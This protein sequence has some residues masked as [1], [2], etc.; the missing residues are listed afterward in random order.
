MPITAITS[1]AP[2]TLA[3]VAVKRQLLE[4]AAAE[5]P[6]GTEDGGE[7]AGG[8]G[9]RPEAEAGEGFLDQV[10]Q[11]LALVG[12]ASDGGG[13]GS[14]LD[15]GA[16]GR[17]LAEVPGLADDERVPAL[18]GEQPPDRLDHGLAGVADADH[19]AAGDKRERQRRIDESNRVGA[20]LGGGHLEQSE[21]I[22]GVAEEGAGE[23]V[24]ALAHEAPIGTEE[25]DGADRR[26]RAADEGCP[27]RRAQ[28][29][30]DPPVVGR[31]AAGPTGAV[32]DE[33]PG[34]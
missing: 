18:G 2:T 5:R 8:V 15:G 16:E 21:G 3:P 33:P 9:G 10:E 17:T 22:E 32:D 11:T 13:A 26:V 1:S 27:L 20:Q 6:I 23:G 30:G 28:L 29:Q 7:Q 14:R 25:E 34:G 24:A 19:A 31:V 12:E 4:L